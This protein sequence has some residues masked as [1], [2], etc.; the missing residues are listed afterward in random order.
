LRLVKKAE[1]SR[2]IPELDTQD[3]VD[4]RLEA[5][6]EKNAELERRLRANE[7]KDQIKSDRERV[8][9]KY[10]L[11]DTDMIEVQKLMTDEKEPIPYW[12]RAAQYYVQLKRVA[13]PTPG[14]VE[15]PVFE[16]PDKDVW[17]GGVGN[18]AELNKIALKQA[19]EA[20]NEIRSGKVAGT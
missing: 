16:M 7:I 2:I 5:L 18:Q 3:A 8:Q 20:F 11:T 4:K 14:T 15:P 9:T 13:E 19:F 1:P 6:A 17:S 12:D 10:S